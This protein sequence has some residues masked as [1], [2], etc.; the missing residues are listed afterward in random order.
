MFDDTEEREEEHETESCEPSEGDYTMTPTGPLGS[1][2]GVGVI[3][4]K[5]LGTFGDEEQ[6]MD[7]IK[8]DMEIHKFW[9]TVWWVS[10]HGN[11]DVVTV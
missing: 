4:G 8:A 9:P 2:V 6:A 1:R 7:A 3:G 5:Y 10:D 11:W